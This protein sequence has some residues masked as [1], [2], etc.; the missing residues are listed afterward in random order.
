MTGFAASF[1]HELLCTR[2][3]RMPQ[4]LLFVF[5][6]MVSLSAVIGW[7]ARST[8]TAV[9]QQITASGLTSAPN[10]FDGTSPLYYAHNSVIYVVLIGALMAIVLGVQATL[11]DRKATTY[12]L[13]LSRPTN[14]VARLLGQLAA[15]SV[16]IA[17]VVALST[18][19]SWV[20]ISAISGGP[21]ELDSTV[22]LILFAALSWL[23]LTGFC[24]LG[25]ISGIYSKKET[26]ALLIPFVI[27]SFITFVLPQLGTAARP[28]ALLNPVPS[29]PAPTGG[30]F[31]AINLVTG[32]FAVTEQFKHAS[33]ILLRDA[34]TTG[35]P[36]PGVIAVAVFVVVLALAVATTTRERMRS[37]LND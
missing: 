7:S 31:D 18:V 4:L 21:L 10:P 27:W 23:L 25:M 34:T 2:R 26:T 11:R 5:L 3:A 24:V 16:V 29:V 28:V 17:S 12:N 33:A 36:V 8:V 14:P 15:L 35:D 37:A 1:E 13:V 20:S 22:R 32:P 6:G 9:Y 30:V 19:V